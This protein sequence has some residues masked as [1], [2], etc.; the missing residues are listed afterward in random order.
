MRSKKNVV[1]DRRPNPETVENTLAFMV[2]KD[3]GRFFKIKA[4]EVDSLREAF[5]HLK[6]HN[7]HIR[8][9]L[10]SWER[11]HSLWRNI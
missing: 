1:P 6:E 11:F 3:E 5:H 2:A 7:V 9:Y 8:K 4:N 10:T